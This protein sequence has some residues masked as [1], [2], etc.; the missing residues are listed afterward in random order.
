MFLLANGTHADNGFVI[1]ALEGLQRRAAMG[2]DSKHSGKTM[3][4][5]LDRYCS[6]TS[7]ERK[8]CGF[9]FCGNCASRLRAWRRAFWGVESIVDNE[10]QRSDPTE[11]MLC[12]IHSQ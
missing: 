6:C 1:A 10:G 11:A 5:L 3:R 4:W 2:T 9:V 8:F 12:A 7:S